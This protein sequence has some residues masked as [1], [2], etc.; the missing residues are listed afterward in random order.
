LDEWQT[1]IKRLGALGFAAVYTAKHGNTRGGALR[2]A[3]HAYRFLDGE[4]VAKI[5]READESDTVREEA[6]KQAAKK[7][8][9]N[10]LNSRIRRLTKWPSRLHPSNRRK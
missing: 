1:L 8:S 6:A 7:T 4:D 9:A 3:S 2:V 10:L 5:N